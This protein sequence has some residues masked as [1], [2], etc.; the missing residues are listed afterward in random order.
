M[1]LGCDATSTPLQEV[2]R[3]SKLFEPRDIDDNAQGLYEKSYAVDGDRRASV[4]TSE[5]DCI[6][7]SSSRSSS[8]GSDYPHS[9]VVSASWRTQDNTSESVIRT[10]KPKSYWRATEEEERAR[11]SGEVEQRRRYNSGEHNHQQQTSVVNSP[12]KVVSSSPEAERGENKKP[13]RFWLG[14][15]VT[16]DERHPFA[17]TATVNDTRPR[18]P[19]RG[20]PVCEV[21]REARELCNEPHHNDNRYHGMFHVNPLSYDYDLYGAT[22][23][24]LDTHQQSGLLNSDIPREYEHDGRY[25]N[26]ER[27][28][29]FRDSYNRFIQSPVLVSNKV[30]IN[31]YVY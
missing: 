7:S 3:P 31:I 14:S 1:E 30:E 26:D 18:D 28:Q 12:S 27:V 9:P 22:D 2:P 17:T 6:V 13:V 20:E 10:D 21:V 23:H 15:E 16:S 5:V 11:E 25:L 4:D 24:K 8:T 29:G 19:L